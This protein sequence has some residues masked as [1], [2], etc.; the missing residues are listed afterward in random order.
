MGHGQA[1]LT[2]LAKGPAEDHVKDHLLTLSSL[3]GRQTL[4]YLVL[5]QIQQFLRPALVVF[6]KLG[7]QGP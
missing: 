7:M 5:Y 4:V 1:N 3:C 2:G 6:Q